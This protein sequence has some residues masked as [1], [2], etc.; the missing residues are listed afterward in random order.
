M[1]FRRRRRPLPGNGKVL[2][3]ARRRA[4]DDVRRV[5]EQQTQVDRLARDVRRALGGRT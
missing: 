3:E 2:A 1:I 4:E 5:R